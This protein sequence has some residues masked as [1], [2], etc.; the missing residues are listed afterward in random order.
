MEYPGRIMG[1][2]T[3]PL[4]HYRAARRRPGGISM[5]LGGIAAGLV[6][7]AEH[8]CGSQGVSG[9]LGCSALLF[10]FIE[11]ASSCC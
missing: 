11:N 5:A 3:R 10:L 7:K 4:G 1:S 8:L 6:A 9:Y 2:R